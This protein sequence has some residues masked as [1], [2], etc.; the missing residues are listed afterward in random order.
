MSKKRIPLEFQNHPIEF[1]EALNRGMFRAVGKYVVDGDT[2]D[3]FI[4]LGW[5]HYNYLPIRIKDLDTPEL[6]GT[7]GEERELA[8]QAKARAETLLADQ[9]VLIKTSKGKVSF[10]RFVGEVFFIAPSDAFPDLVP[11]Q[12]ERKKEPPLF[13]FSFSDVMK[14]EGYIKQKKQ[15]A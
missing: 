15:P 1:S 3:F 7:S 12:I 14:L 2:A 6:R 5:Y 10:G 4:D 13:L 9:P 8:Y 11:L